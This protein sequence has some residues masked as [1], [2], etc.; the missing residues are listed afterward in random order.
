MDVVAGMSDKRKD[1]I[2]AALNCLRKETQVDLHKKRGTRTMTR[3]IAYFFIINLY[4]SG[5]GDFKSPST[6]SV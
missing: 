1:D 6:M 3:E 5:I 2:T 4:H